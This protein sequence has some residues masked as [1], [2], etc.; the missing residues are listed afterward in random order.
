MPIITGTGQFLKRFTD[1]PWSLLL[2][3]KKSVYNKMQRN[4]V[5]LAVR[6]GRLQELVFEGL[7]RAF[8]GEGPWLYFSIHVR[9]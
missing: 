5:I 8:L 1:I 7:R 3:Q 4:A 2:L 9:N 6:G